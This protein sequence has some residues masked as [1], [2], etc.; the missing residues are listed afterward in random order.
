M[1]LIEFLVLLIIAGICGAVAQALAGFTR[2]GCLLSIAVGFV[3]ALLGSWLAD[4]LNL[5]SLFTI[6]IGGSDFPIVWS[7]IGGA[8][9]AAIL[10][11]V[12]R[13]SSRPTT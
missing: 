6:S 2:G 13:P 8:L 1:S 5:P 10:G 11:L 3:G 4:A 9:F 7:I 12:A